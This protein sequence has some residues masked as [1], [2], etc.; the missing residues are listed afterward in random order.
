[1]ASMLADEAEVLVSML[2]DVM[3]RIVPNLLQGDVAL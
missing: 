1:M 2:E 3:G